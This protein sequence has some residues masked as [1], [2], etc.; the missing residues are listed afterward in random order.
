MG[1]VVLKKTK[2]LNGNYS[3]DELDITVEEWKSILQAVSVSDNYRLLKIQ[4]T[5]C[6]II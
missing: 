3:C 2:N 6:R 4:L 5:F 1:N